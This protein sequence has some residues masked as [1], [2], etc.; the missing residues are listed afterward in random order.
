MKPGTEHGFSLHNIVGHAGPFT[1]SSKCSVGFSHR[2]MTCSYAMF[3]WRNCWDAGTG[4]FIIRKCQDDLGQAFPILT[5][6]G[7]ACTYIPLSSISSLGVMV[8]LSVSM[9]NT[10]PVIKKLDSMF[11]SHLDFLWLMA[12]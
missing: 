2:Q 6:E 3:L 11:P 10:L 12:G 7:G 1:V 9:F 4:F 5:T 8:R